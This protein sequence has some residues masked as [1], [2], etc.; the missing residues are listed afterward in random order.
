MQTVHGSRGVMIKR[1]GFMMKLFDY[2]FYRVYRAYRKKDSSPEMYATNA[3]ALLQFFFLLS[4]LAIIRL[5]FDFPTPDKVYIIPVIVLIFGINWYK[6]G[7]NAD[8]KRMDLQWGEEDAR[9]RKRKGWVLV[10]SLVGFILFPIMIGILK[11]NLNL[12]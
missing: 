10:L 9:Q 11:H 4:I 5:F 3:L 12:I 1:K 2:I 8:V 6:Y 7:F